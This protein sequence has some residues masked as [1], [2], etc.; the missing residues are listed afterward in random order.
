MADII[1]SPI[2]FLGA[3]VLSFN[4]SIGLGSAQESSLSVDLVE[5]CDVGDVFLP[6]AGNP[7]FQVGAP[8]YFST[9]ISGAG[10]NFGGVLST[11]SGNQSGSGR[12]FNVKVVD[13]RQLLQNVIVIMDSYLGP[14]IQGVNYYNVYAGYES[15]VLGG[16]CQTFGSSGS[17]ERGTPYTSIISKLQQFNPTIC[18]PTGYNYTINWGSFPTGTPEFYRL[19]GPSSTLL[20][21]LQ[22][23]CDVLGLEFY[24]YMMP[25]G[26]INVGTIDLKTPPN[27]FGNIIDQFD[28][29]ATDLT[30]GQ[31]LRNEVTKTVMFG[32][33]QHYLSP[34]DKFNYY[35]GEEWDG[36]QFV[37]VIPTRFDECYGFW[38]N[39]RVQD[40]NITLNKPLKD[41]NGP[42]EISEQDIKAAM[43]S[44]NAWWTRV[45]NDQIAGKFNDVVRKNYELD[46][47]GIRKVFSAVNNDPNIPASVRYKALT[48]IFG[49]PTKAKNIADLFQ[50]DLQNIHGFV[51]NLGTTYYGKQFFV[52]LN[53]KI[54]YYK[55]E[56]FQELIFSSEPTNAGGWVDPGTPVLGL[57][58]PDLGS[59][60][61]TDERISCFAVFAINDDDVPKEDKEDPVGQD[62]YGEE[63]YGPEGPSPGE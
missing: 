29:K 21:L 39:K 17:T 52:P 35:F 31:E 25:G 41:G 45:T 46:N 32:E 53:E 6:A 30:Y 63:E 47:E 56:N 12:T 4:T 15:D 28:G 43:A 7:L 34:V 16:N 20:Q 2:K 8:V 62:K 38:I 26:V 58:D 51:Q 3:T 22:D 36:N 54:C 11:W 33:K 9:S 13:P 40:L 10:F 61:E 44:Y 23:V 48:D 49:C 60:R 42:F 50:Q 27:S 24:V 5:D 55:G 1:T 14:P 18:S 59:F 37:P 19:P 57:N